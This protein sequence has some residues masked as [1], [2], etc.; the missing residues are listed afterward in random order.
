MIVYSVDAQS[1]SLTVMPTTVLE[2]DT[3]PSD[4]GLCNNLCSR[5]ITNIGFSSP[6]QQFWSGLLVNADC[7]YQIFAVCLIPRLFGPREVLIWTRWIM[8]AW[9]VPTTTTVYQ[10]PY[11]LRVERFLVLSS[12]V[13]V[14]SRISTSGK[15]TNLSNV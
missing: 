3:I 4:D 13:V 2:V 7:S 9:K 14:R 8:S 5:N 11:G 6:V 1:V 10:A 15:R 12:G